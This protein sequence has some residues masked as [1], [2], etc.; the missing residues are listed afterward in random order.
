[1]KRT[2]FFVCDSRHF[3][4]VVSGNMNVFK[5]TLDGTCKSRNNIIEQ[6]QINAS[7]ESDI[8]I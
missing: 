7:L 8:E 5:I 1:M 6:V 4:M 2:H 3:S